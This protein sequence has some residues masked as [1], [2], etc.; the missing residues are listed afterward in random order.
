MEEKQDM[1]SMGSTS[2]ITVE[3]RNCGSLNRVNRGSVK[4]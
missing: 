4:K 3:C 1:S 2:M